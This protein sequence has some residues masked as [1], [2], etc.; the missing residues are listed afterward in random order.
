MD[1]FFQNST[2][3]TTEASITKLLFPHCCHC[4]LNSNIPKAYSEI[5]MGFRNAAELWL[6]CNWQVGHKV[7]P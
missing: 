4:Y 1:V 3:Y 6:F 2:K 7:K 5:D